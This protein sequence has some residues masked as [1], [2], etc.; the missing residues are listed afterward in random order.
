MYIKNRRFSS[1]F[2]GCSPLQLYINLKEKCN[3]NAYFS[4]TNRYKQAYENIKSG[5]NPD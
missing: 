2:K 3:A 1:K 4:Y 5:L